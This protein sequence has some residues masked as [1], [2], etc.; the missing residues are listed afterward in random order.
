MV[1]HRVNRHFIVMN[2]ICSQISKRSPQFRG[3]HQQ[4]AHELLRHLTEGVRAEEVKRQ[5]SAI[6]KVDVACYV[7]ILL[8]G[9]LSIKY[10]RTE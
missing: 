3:M 10:L 9:L 8:L 1:K 2:L 7:V 6:L 5:K 4:D